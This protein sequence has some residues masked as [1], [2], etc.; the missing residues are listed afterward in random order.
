MRKFSI[1][2][3]KTN[4]FVLFLLHF[5]KIIKEFQCSKSFKFG[6]CYA[7]DRIAH[8]LLCLIGLCDLL[9]LKMSM[10][11]TLVCFKSNSKSRLTWYTAPKI[12]KTNRTFSRFSSAISCWVGSNQTHGRCY[13]RKIESVRQKCIA[14]RFTYLRGNSAEMHIYCISEIVQTTTFR[15]DLSGV[16]LTHAISLLISY[17]ICEFHSTNYPQIHACKWSCSQEVCASF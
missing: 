16:L 15:H 17:P 9:D 10:L 8:E 13:R 5:I 7:N 12:Y 1:I 14:H 3:M 11:A 2:R 4:H 6:M